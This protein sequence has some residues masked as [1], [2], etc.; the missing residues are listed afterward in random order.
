MIILGV[1]ETSH[2]ASVSLIKD[3]NIL[4]SGQSYPNTE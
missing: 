2:D 4:F 3:G 1:N